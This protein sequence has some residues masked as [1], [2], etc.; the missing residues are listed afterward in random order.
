MVVGWGLT[1]ILA[2]ILFYSS[3]VHSWVL[4]NNWWKITLR[5]L[6]RTNPPFCSGLSWF[7]WTLL[8]VN[9]LGIN[10]DYWIWL[11]WGLVLLLGI[12]TDRI[13]RVLRPAEI[14]GI[15]FVL[16]LI[17]YWLVRPDVGFLAVLWLGLVGI[18][19]AQRRCIRKFNTEKE[20][21]IGELERRL[22]MLEGT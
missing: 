2:M 17:L 8:P 19:L 7:P 22:K 6:K 1:F 5:E 3:G 9:P 10:V 13:L 14:L 21:W 20:K 11:T 12:F 16:S 15:N 4:E 18:Y